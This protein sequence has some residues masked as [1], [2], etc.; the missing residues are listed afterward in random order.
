MNL[1]RTAT[2]LVTG[3]SGGIGG[4]IADALAIRGV[5]V[6]ASGR[7]ADALAAVAARTGGPAVVADLATVAGID[8]LVASSG[9]IDLLVANAGLPASGRLWD[10]ESEQ[11]QRAIDVNLRAP[12]LLARALVPGMVE[13]GVG[14][15]VLVSSLAGLTA[16]SAASLYNA[17]KFALRG[18]GHALRQDLHGTG[19][20]VSLVMP[21]FVRDAG[22]FA[23]LVATLP[24]GVGTT[25]P[26]RVAQATIAAIERDRGEVLVA[27]WPMRAGARIGGLLPGVAAR[28]TRAAGGA[29]LADRIA[30]AQRRYR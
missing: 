6:V 24:R 25:S 17:T 13:R 11:I 15:V 19:V 21:G 22:M 12:I 23:G 16:T 29:E 14:H 20:G 3:A 2:A 4:A 10:Y 9:P 1:D 8:D 5:R 27:P 18:F 30:E 7:D 26:A 28:A